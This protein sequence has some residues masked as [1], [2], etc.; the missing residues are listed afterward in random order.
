[1]CIRGN[2]IFLPGSMCFV[3]LPCITLFCES[4]PCNLN[5]QQNILWALWIFP[6]LSVGLEIFSYLGSCIVGKLEQGIYSVF[7]PDLLT[8]LFP[9]DLRWHWVPLQ[10]NST[11]YVSDGSVWKHSGHLNKR[12]RKDHA[13][14]LS[15]PSS[16]QTSQLSLSQITFSFQF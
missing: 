6:L 10:K 4:S 1:M 9:A 16:K 8:F 14:V 11:I 5:L 12:E 3:R 2:K 13:W 15:N 7:L